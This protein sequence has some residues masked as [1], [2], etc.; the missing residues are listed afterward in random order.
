MTD[1]TPED[2]T[3]WVAQMDQQT[4]MV[5]DLAA[6]VRRH[7]TDGSGCP[8]PRCPSAS[9]TVLLEMAPA[10]NVRVLLL[11]ALVLLADGP[12]T[13]QPSTG[14]TP[15]ERAVVDAAKTW[16]WSGDTAGGHQQAEG[17]LMAAVDALPG[18]PDHG[19]RALPHGYVPDACGDHCD[20]RPCPAGQLHDRCSPACQPPA[21]PDTSPEANPC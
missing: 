12:S 5:R 16:R 8:L 11:T 6:R 4:A 18:R 3:G 15:A 7:W 17:A 1:T 2:V 21:A 20:N 14:M 9:L 13:D 10:D 19:P